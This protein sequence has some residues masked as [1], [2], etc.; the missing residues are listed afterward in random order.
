MAELT[1]IFTLTCKRD[2]HLSCICL[3]TLIDRSTCPISL[4]I[5]DDGSLSCDDWNFLQQQLGKFR[6]HPLEAREQFVATKAK[7]HLHCLLYRRRSPLAFKLID[8]PLLAS[9]VSS[10]IHFLDSDVLFLRSFTGLF[11]RHEKYL[12]TEDVRLSFSLQK[13]LRNRYSMPFRF[14]SGYLNFPSKWHDLDFIETYL[15]TDWHW[16]FEWLVEQSCFALIFGANSQRPR[17]FNISEF[18]CDSQLR[19]LRPD[20]IAVH[21]IGNLKSHASR[22]LAERGQLDTPTGNFST[23]DARL[24]NV[25]DVF[26]RFVARRM[27][28]FWGTRGT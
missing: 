28:W 14:N 26:N 11:E 9:Q 12:A 15:A 5:L 27:P 23:C 18:V 25:G 20:T 16:D 21:L 10:N 1:E 8:M 6:P 24:C 19:T 22:L 3:K 7:N 17:K 4:N 13:A 2:L